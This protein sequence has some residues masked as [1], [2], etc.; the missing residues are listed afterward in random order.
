MSPQPP[1]YRQERY[2]AEV[3]NEDKIFGKKTALMAPGAES[4]VQ[5]QV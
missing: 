3:I 5:N 4:P 2:K 1:S